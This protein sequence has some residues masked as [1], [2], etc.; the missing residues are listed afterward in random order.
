MPVS[1]NWLK[2]VLRRG[3]SSKVDFKIDLTL[4]TDQQK[5]EFAKDLSAMAN[6]PGGKGYIIVGVDDKGRPKGV[7]PRVNLSEE[8]LQQVARSRIDPPVKFSVADLDFDSKKIVLLEIPRSIVRPHQ[9]KNT[10]TF[11]IRRGKTTDIATTSEVI[12]MVRRRIEIDRGILGEYDQYAIGQLTKIMQK[13]ALRAMAKIGFRK[14]EVVLESN[15]Y[16]GK[17]KRCIAFADGFIDDISVRFYF[18][19]FGRGLDQESLFRTRDLIEDGWSALLGKGRIN[20][21]VAHIFLL[22]MG[23]TV[24][25]RLIETISHHP[26]AVSALGS[27]IIY[28]GLGIGEIDFGTDLEIRPMRCLPK[29]F[30]QKVKSADDMESRLSAIIDWMKEHHEVLKLLMRFFRLVKSSA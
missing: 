4:S 5:V 18:F 8:R 16:W 29:F 2:R 12:Q 25:R 27:S 28:A 24:N 20:R 13:H 22:M 15:G 30:V 17:A 9:A 14:G 11:Y 10:G 19:F 7:D 3:E 23:G 21:K 6:T 26:C 1:K